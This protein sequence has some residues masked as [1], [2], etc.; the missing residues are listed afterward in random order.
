MTNTAHAEILTRHYPTQN[1]VDFLVGKTGYSRAAFTKTYGLGENHILL[2]VQGRK[3]S[4]GDALSDAL[5]DA[6]ESRGQSVERLLGEQYGTTDLQVAWLKWREATRK[7]TRLPEIRPGVGSP[8]ARLVRAVGSI[9]KTAQLLRV[10]DIQVRKAMNQAQIPEPV[11][12]A[13]AEIA[14]ADTA[15]DFQRRQIAYFKDKDRKR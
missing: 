5:H 11:L 8:T 7:R 6:L 15:Q 13:I 12:R 14:G 1:P 9:A 3:E 4:V 2:V 10:R